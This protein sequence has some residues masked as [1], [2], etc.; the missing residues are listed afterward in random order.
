MRTRYYIECSVNVKSSISFNIAQLV[1]RCSMRKTGMF[2]HP[3]Y[4]FLTA[5]PDRIQTKPDVRLIEL[6]AY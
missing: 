1:P 6:K 3:D 2:P 4:G 5:S